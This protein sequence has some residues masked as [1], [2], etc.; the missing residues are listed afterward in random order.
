MP[1]SCWHL[2]RQ[3]HQPLSAPERRTRF[4][5]WQK[6]EDSLWLV[7]TKRCPASDCIHVF[8]RWYPKFLVRAN[9]DLNSVTNQT[10][11]HHL[12][13][14][15]TLCRSPPSMLWAVYQYVVLTVSPRQNLNLRHCERIRT[16]TQASFRHE[17]EQ[18]PASTAVAKEKEEE[19]DDHALPPV[20]PGDNSNAP[21]SRT[22]D[23][24]NGSRSVQNTFWLSR[25]HL[26]DRTI[27]CCRYLLRADWHHYASLLACVSMILVSNTFLFESN[28][29]HKYCGQRPILN[30]TMQFRDKVQCCT[31]GCILSCPRRCCKQ[32]K[33]TCCMRRFLVLKDS[34]GTLFK[35]KDRVCTY[36]LIWHEIV[37]VPSFM[38]TYA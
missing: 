35:I 21:P 29:S 34:P 28:T 12:M 23:K 26:D 31:H 7:L 1:A 37:P 5:K 17:E 9:N 4:P 30:Y 2:I 13:S 11:V 18:P 3:S 36:F 32:R 38:T 15:H 8:M 10:H 14:Q 22:S 19:E 25:F 33:V 16:G 20:S 6:F 24:Q 27:L